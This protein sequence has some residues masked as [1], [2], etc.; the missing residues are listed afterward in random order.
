MRGNSTDEAQV[1]KYA[2]EL[3][4][5]LEVY[6][7]ILAKQP[8]LAGDEV[9]LADLFHLPYGKMSK[10]LGFADLYEGKYLNVK[11]WFDALE[12]RGSWIQANA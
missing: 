6:D 2:E 7:S 10:T 9:T 3:D 4:A 11:R 8:Y 12:A 5:T 1:A